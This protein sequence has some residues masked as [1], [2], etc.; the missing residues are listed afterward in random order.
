MIRAILKNSPNIDFSRHHFDKTSVAVDVDENVLFPYTPS[1][2]APSFVGL[3]I[4]D[5]KVL[6]TKSLS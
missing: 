2:V 3:E 4:F 1:F 6:K 5:T